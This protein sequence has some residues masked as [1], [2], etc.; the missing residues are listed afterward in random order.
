MAKDTSAIKDILYK[1]IDTKISNSSILKKYQANISKFMEERSEGL[2]SP[3]PCDRLYFRDDD[4]VSFFAS[5]DLDPKFV[6]DTLDQ[7]YYATISNFNPKAAK[8]EFTVTQLCVLRH[9]VLKNDK[10]N[11][12]IAALYLAFSGKFYPSVHYRSFPNNVPVPY[13]MEYV[14]NN[15]LSKKYDLVQYGSVIKTIES[16]CNTWLSTYSSKFKSFDDD[17]V[18]YLIQ[19]LHSRIGSFIKNIAEEYYKAYANK[20]NFMTYDSDSYEQDDYHLADSDSLRME[21]TIESSMQR[22]N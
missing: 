17:D 5:L 20:D 14:V 18:V 21:K 1:D 12:N 13:V 6:L 22:I 7:T 2:F 9:F 11:I 4:R 10:K 19:Q 16:I 8:D 3:I 15:N